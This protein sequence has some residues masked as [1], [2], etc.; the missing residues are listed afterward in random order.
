MFSFAIQKDESSFMESIAVHQTCILN[1]WPVIIVKEPSD[2]PS[3]FIPCGTV[4]WCLQVLGR[5]V[6]P[7]YYPVFLLNHLYRKIWKTE[8]WPLGKRVFIKP[9]DKYKRFTGF[10]TKGGYRNKKKPPYWCSDIVSFKNEW[11]YYVTNG[12]VVAS[13]WY[14]GDEENMPDP[15]VLDLFIPTYYCGA[16][17]FGT[18]ETGELALVEAN[19]PF[20]CGWYGRDHKAYT[21]WLAHGWKYMKNN[22]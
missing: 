5:E 7:D 19:H 22:T 18:L 13:G 20:A 10:I 1:K 21:L 6:E 17:D 15:P 4:E 9:A 16:L 2:V 12:E 3:D 8:K 11:R 14:A